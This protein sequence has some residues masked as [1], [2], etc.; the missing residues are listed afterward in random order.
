MVARLQSVTPAKITLRG[1]IRS[2]IGPEI[3]DANA[4]TIRLTQASQP[5][6]N[7]VR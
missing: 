3:A 5:N 2:A 6:S 4:N 7:F 1:P